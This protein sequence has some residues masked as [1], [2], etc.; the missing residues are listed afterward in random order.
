MPTFG[1]HFYR[2][3]DSVAP[4]VRGAQAHA[5]ASGSTHGHY[6]SVR[7]V[8]VFLTASYAAVSRCL[9][10]CA[11]PPAAAHAHVVPLIALKAGRYAHHFYTVR[12]CCLASSERRRVAS[13]A[14]RAAVA[15][16]PSA[17]VR[18]NS[19]AKSGINRLL[20]ADDKMDAMFPEARR[21]LEEA[22]P[23]VHK[24]VKAEMKRQWCAA[25]LPIL[26]LA[27]G[28]CA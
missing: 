1:R 28:L 14:L 17:S 7:L 18:L 11:R 22:D 4:R 12:A 20:F 6:T 21:T 5:T 15:A 23:E 16:V 8:C 26:C 13:L 27:V 24:L 10:H 19:H 25:A 2:A 3:S 9:K